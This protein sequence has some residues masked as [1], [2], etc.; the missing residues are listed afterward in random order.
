MRLRNSG[1]KGSAAAANEIPKDISGGTVS[2]TN[3]DKLAKS[4]EAQLLRV[5]GFKAIQAV[6]DKLLKRSLIQ[7]VLP[8]SKTSPR[9]PLL[10]IRRSF[11]ATSWAAR[12]GA[13]T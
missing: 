1:K 3:L 8:E 7:L 9:I 10:P 12:A 11:S 13:P 2:A 4:L 6:L 5:G